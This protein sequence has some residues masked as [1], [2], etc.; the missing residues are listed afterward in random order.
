[1]FDCTS[2]PLPTSGGSLSS[3]RELREAARRNGRAGP[4]VDYLRKVCKLT[5]ARLQCSTEDKCM[6]RPRGV[7]PVSLRPPSNRCDFGADLREKCNG[8]VVRRTPLQSMTT[9]VRILHMSHSRRQNA[10]T[11]IMPS[12]PAFAKKD[13][14]DAKPT[15]A[16]VL[17]L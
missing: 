6:P 9:D 4:P 7:R 3:R 13:S 11:R 12:P 2:T 16:T 15:H 5:R 1:M 10:G 14:E 17:K 8:S